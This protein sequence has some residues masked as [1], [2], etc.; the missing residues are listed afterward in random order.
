MLLGRSLPE[1]VQTSAKADR[2]AENNNNENWEDGTHLSAR[3]K[4]TTNQQR[5]QMMK[6]EGRIGLDGG[7][8]FV[9]M[10]RRDH[11]IQGGGI[12]HWLGG[13]GGDL[14]STTINSG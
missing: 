11:C 13:G 9:T 10:R 2:M 5:E 12:E 6:N 8:T 1:A 7:G 14:A 4:I 3:G